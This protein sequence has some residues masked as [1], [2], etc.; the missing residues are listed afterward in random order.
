[1]SLFNPFQNIINILITFNILKKPGLSSP[2]LI[3][4]TKFEF[5]E[6]DLAT[7]DLNS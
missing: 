6:P 3:F 5:V 7:F 4:T 1:M 2:D